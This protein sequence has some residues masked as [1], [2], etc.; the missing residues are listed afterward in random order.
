MTMS[1]DML[2]HP[3][4][5]TNEQLIYI[6]QQRHLR[7]PNILSMQRDDLLLLFHQFCV[8]YGQRKYKDSGRGKVLNKN[9]NTSPETTTKLNITNNAHVNVES[10]Q[11]HLKYTIQNDRL[12]PPLDLISGHIN[13]KMK[14]ETKTV[15]N[16]FDKFKRKVPIDPATLVTDCPPIKKE[17]K[18]I[19]WP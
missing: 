14:L 2:L 7:V 4:L 15:I 19:T 8:P 16:E 18:P 3:E 12:K 10:R 13:K 9:R 17:R 1:C 11:I 6:I 5:M